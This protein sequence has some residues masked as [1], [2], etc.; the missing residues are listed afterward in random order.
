MNGYTL[1]RVVVD[2]V[3]R[4]SEKWH[5]RTGMLSNGLRVLLQRNEKRPTVCLQI[6]IYWPP[7]G[8]YDNSLMHMLEHMIV[9]STI[10][11]KKG[12]WR[13][14]E[15]ASGGGWTFEDSICLGNGCSPNQVRSC[16]SILC[17]A[18]KKEFTRVPFE[19]ERRRIMAELRE[20][21]ASLTEF[22]HGYWLGKMFPHSPYSS[23]V[24]GHLDYMARMTFEELVA[25]R[26][27]ILRAENIV[28]GATGNI[29]EDQIMRFLEENFGDLPKL[30]EEKIAVVLSSGNPGINLVQR[31]GN[32]LTSFIIG[33][34][35]EENPEISAYRMGPD[36]DSLASQFV[37]TLLGQM[38]TSRAA[39]MGHKLGHYRVN[40]GGET[41][42]G[43]ETL[44]L[45]GTTEDSDTINRVVLEY[46]KDIRR[47]R[48]CGPTQQEVRQAMN[49]FAG[50]YMNLSQGMPK[51]TIFG[52]ST[53][54]NEDCFETYREYVAK[55]RRVTPAL[56]RNWVNRH[57]APDCSQMTVAGDVKNIVPFRTIQHFCGMV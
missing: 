30:N 56:I 51:R 8:R 50:Y 39:Q 36:F 6:N 18:T 42:A 20:S 53:L 35:V 38:W 54:Y 46:I 4:G 2:Q 33:Q 37:T 3:R 52:C 5:V 26:K 25:F 34:C 28:V 13:I 29:N 24:G 1:G 48:R 43:A 44:W 14:D 9:R 57:L 11:Q 31:S 22:T 15:A 7:I 49:N 10:G 27:L 55:I 16:L 12:F 40:T 41:K 47:L 23:P 19:Y 17:S 32:G 45:A 21:R